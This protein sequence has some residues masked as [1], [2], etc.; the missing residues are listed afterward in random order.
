MRRAVFALFALIPLAAVAAPA[1]A[2]KAAPEPAVQKV[3]FTNK[4]VDGKKVW[5]PADA[6]LKFQGKVEITLINEL[7]DPHGF[8]APGLTK[9]P[10]V[11][12]GGETKTVQVEG[13]KGEYKFVCQLHPA[14]VG[15]TIKID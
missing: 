7:K 8:S 10:I 6:N 5:L 2:K 13:K 9:E 3:T 11:V 12:L 1:F 15:G 14:H 4:E